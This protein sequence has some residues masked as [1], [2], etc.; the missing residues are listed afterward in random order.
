MRLRTAARQSSP[1]SRRLNLTGEKQ[2]PL[3]PAPR[4]ASSVNGFDLKDTILFLTTSFQ[5]E[6]L[7]AWNV[8]GLVEG[9]DPVLKNEFIL[10]TAHLDHLPPDDKGEVRNGADDNASGCAGVMEIAGVVALKP[11]QRSVV[12]VLFAGEELMGLGSRHFLDACP[13]PRDKIIADI[14]LDMIG[15]R[16]KAHESDRA[17]YAL[18]SDNL[19]PELKKLIM[20]VNDRT[21]RWPLLYNRD[22]RTGS[23][24]LVFEW[25]GR[26]PG[27]FFWSGDQPDRH[28]ATDDAEKI[29]YDQAEKISRL[30]Y[31]IVRE[32]AAR[33]I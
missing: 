7:P 31:E 10:V 12:L 32:I 22:P 20:E 3:K 24:N 30:A 16:E 5:D 27:V 17:I 14:N 9:T 28:R 11:F 13:V 19:R 4:E 25:M 6:N 1:K 8:V 18:D 33:G 15:R 21:V 29:D 2:S 26:I 23:D